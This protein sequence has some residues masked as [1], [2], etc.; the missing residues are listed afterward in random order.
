MNLDFLPNNVKE[1][2]KKLDVDKLTEIRFRIGYPVII[3]YDNKKQYLFY[4]SKTNLIGQAILCRKVDIDEIISNVTDKS[5]YAYNENIKNGFLTTK[6]GIRIGIAGECV[7][8]NDKLITIKNITSLNIR[9]PHEIIDVSNKI[10]NYVFSSEK[11]KNTLII[12]PPFY[13][14]TTMLKDLTLKLNEKNIGNILVIDERY[15]FSRING[16]NIDVIQNSSKLFAFERGIRSLS[17]N[18][19]ITDELCGANDW[20]CV[21]KAVDSGVKIIASCH[22][23]DVHRLKNKTEFIDGLFEIYVVLYDFGKPGRI[24]YVYDKEFNL[25]CG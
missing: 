19:V 3:K 8:D 10:F 20:L 24:K 13:G 21:K 16:E 18:I 23:D 9:I 7:I 6:D 2:I 1:Q 4:E 17:P 5:I 14:K 12:S 15:E 11:V 22:S 25:I